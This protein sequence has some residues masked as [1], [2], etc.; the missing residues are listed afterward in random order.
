VLAD[1]GLILVNSGD[2]SGPRQTIALEPGKAGA[3]PSLAW[4]SKKRDLP[5]V[6][7]FLSRGDHL[8][9]VNDGGFAGCTVAKTGEVVW[10]E[11]LGTKNFSASP[12]LIDGKVY[13]VN[14]GGDVYVFAAEPKYKLLAKNTLDDLVRA[15]PAVAD[16]RLYVRGQS[17]LY[18]IGK[19]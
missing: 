2:G 12:V 5:Y 11:R 6:P 18:C 17:T 8:Y 3:K 7:C 15:S 1:N 19:K 9:W 4:E 16:G 14:E 13:A 10:Q